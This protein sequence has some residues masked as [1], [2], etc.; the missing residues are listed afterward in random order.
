MVIEGRLTFVVDVEAV[1]VFTDQCIPSR[2]TS[3]GVGCSAESDNMARNSTSHNSIAPNSRAYTTP[4]YQ[5]QLE[6][7]SKL[8]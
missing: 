1:A 3:T 7:K 6:K 5:S 2:T 8:Y 4:L